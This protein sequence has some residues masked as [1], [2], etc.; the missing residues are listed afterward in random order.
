MVAVVVVLATAEF[1]AREAPAVV[2]Q[3]FQRQMANQ[4]QLTLVVVVVVVAQQ[5]EHL[6]AK[7]AQ[8]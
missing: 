5:L 1:K 3:G 7:A 2:V 6:V 8:V 4:A